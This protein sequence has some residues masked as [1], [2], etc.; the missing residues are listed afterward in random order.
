MCAFDALWLRPVVCVDRWLPIHVSLPL[1]WLSWKC[2]LIDVAPFHSPI[3]D[4]A[5]VRCCHTL[6]IS[7]NTLAIIYFLAACH[8]AESYDHPLQKCAAVS[9][10]H[11]VSSLPC[12]GNSWCSFVLK[13]RSL[14]RHL[15]RRMRYSGV[16]GHHHRNFFPKKSSCMC[17]VWTVAERHLLS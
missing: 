4:M 15:L 5:T 16:K 9:S 1:M 14:P 8:G 13:I 11:N 3:K 10:F 6:I 7:T 2:Y 17:L 12:V